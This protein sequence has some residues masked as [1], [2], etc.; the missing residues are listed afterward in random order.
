MSDEPN[1]PA[2]MGCLWSMLLVFVGLVAGFVLSCVLGYW[3]LV[4]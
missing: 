1:K 4:D 2:R 3:L